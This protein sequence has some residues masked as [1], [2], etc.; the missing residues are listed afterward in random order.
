VIFV[1]WEQA[2]AY[3]AWVGKRL[4]TEAEWEKAARGT[5][6]RIYPWGGGGIGCDQANYHGCVGDTAQVASYPQGA[7]PYG[8]LD[9]AGNVWEWVAD[10]Y[11]SAYYASSPDSNPGGPASGEQRVLRGGSWFDVEQDVR[12]AVRYDY[13]LSYSG[14]RISFRCALSGSG[15]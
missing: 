14:N 9:M 4:P 12:A 1:D 13:G 2:V 11:D 8:A 5:D 10:W 15:S 7:S 6:R 3:C